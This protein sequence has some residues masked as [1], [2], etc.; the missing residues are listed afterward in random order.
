VISAC[1]MHIPNPHDSCDG[2]AARPKEALQ[3]TS[4]RSVNTIA[5]KPGCSGNLCCET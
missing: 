3:I 2:K 5:L 1:G 4:R